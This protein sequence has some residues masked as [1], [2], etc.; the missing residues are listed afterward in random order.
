LDGAELFTRHGAR[1]VDKA[2]DDAIFPTIPAGTDEAAVYKTFEM[3]YGHHVVYELTR[4]WIVAPG[5]FQYEYRWLQPAGTDAAIRAWADGNFRKV[6]GVTPDK[7]EL[8]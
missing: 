4:Q 7:F 5:P 1:F 6:Y 8:L 3:F 2:D